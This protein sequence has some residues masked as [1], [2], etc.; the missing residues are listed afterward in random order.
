MSKKKFCI[1]FSGAIGSSKTPI[2]TFLSEEIGLPIFNNDSIRTEVLED[3]S[4]TGETIVVER[5]LAYNFRRD[6]RLI[7]MLNRG[8]SF[9]LDASIDRRWD[10]LKPGLE[11]YGYRWFIISLDL[12]K[13]LLLKLYK[14]KGYTISDS[15]DKTIKDHNLFV[16]KNKQEIGLHISDKNFKDRME[17]SLEAVTKWKKL[18]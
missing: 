17:L 14:S 6:E 15:L 3:F 2:A 9:I 7:K 12:K 13:S 5:E 10:M 18:L 1:L 8:E 11:L 16:K 4:D